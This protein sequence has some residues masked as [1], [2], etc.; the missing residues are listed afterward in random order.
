MDFV[1]TI[2]IYSIMTVLIT[3]K[4]FQKIARR[5]QEYNEGKRRA[6]DELESS[7]HRLRMFVEQCPYSVA[8]LDKDMRYLFCSDQ[9]FVSHKIEK[10]PVRG[11]SHYDLFPTSAKRRDIH[12]RCLAGA[13]E[14]N[15]GEKFMI[16][17]SWHWYRWEIRPWYN[18]E[19]DIG[20]VILYSEDITE[21]QRH[22]DRLRENEQKFLTIYENSPL[23]KSL[24]SWPDGRFCDVNS[25]WTE[26]FEFSKEEVLGK[27][28]I[29]LGI[30]Q[31]EKEREV[32]R[33]RL[34]DHRNS[35]NLEMKLYTKSGRQLVVTNNGSVFE[36]NGEK[37]LILT[38]M[39]ITENKK[40]ERQLAATFNQAGVGIAHVSPEG[41]WLRVNRKICE[42]VGYTETE[43]LNLSFQQITHPD[44]L[45]QDIS[46]LNQMLNH[47]IDQYTMEKRYI[48]KDQSTVW[49]N[50]TV[51][52]VWKQNG[53]PDYFISIIEDIDLRKQ[54]EKDRAD[55]AVREHSA[56]VASKLKS[57]FLSN[58]S[59]EIRTPINGVIGMTG[60]L[61][62]T[63]LSSE[64]QDYVNTIRRSGETL[65][66]V[67][68]DILDFSKIEA[69]KLD[70]EMIDFNLS[71]AIEDVRKTLIFSADK[72]NIKF[73][74]DIASNMPVAFKGDP[75]RLKQVLF[76][77]IGNAIK[78]TNKGS[79]S[80]CAYPIYETD[81]EAHI[82]FE[83][84]DTGIG[85]PIEIQDRLF[86]PFTQGDA[87]T[88][89]HFGGTGL[90]LTI[91]KSLIEKMNGHISI[92]SE[93]GSGSTF[94]FDI[95]LKKSSI[96]PLKKAE[97]E[98]PLAS[99]SRTR[100]ARIL[101][102]EDNLV[103]QLITTKMLQKLGYHADA[104]ANG[105]EVLKTLNEIPYDLILMDC[106]M[107]EM[108]GYEASRIIRQS[109]EFPYCNIPILALTANAMAG[110]AK[111]CRSAG[112]N[113]HIA[114][115]VTIEKLGQILEK[116]L[117]ETT[118]SS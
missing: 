97:T 55:L 23:P 98:V 73:S 96:K 78:F 43:L 57:E 52:L 93:E 67:I 111:V 101:V 31:D 22:Q 48:K 69:G 99:S 106:Q 36:L 84:K 26:L 16:N 27:T 72:K 64:Q 59:H 82:K 58:V 12:L 65:L 17:G 44:D 42:I 117:D 81:V 86:R 114:K 109:K 62:D 70:F 108:D 95:T 103:N 47:E 90:G 102:A 30:V 18:D 19:N 32:A 85:I 51:A 21:K 74:T 34:K 45:N 83:V 35:R 49:V 116:Y 118:R 53:Q 110:E 61:S 3:W 91:C 33:Q 79:V 46:L 25:A 9:W 92:Q 6:M 39:D 5:D 60:L 107:P 29:E 7:E 1:L 41:K 75:G 112:M 14:K 77:L 63:N 89:R 68:N 113:D 38:Q 4:G 88:H 56:Q 94:T 20:G 87:S 37:Y 8:M 54:A 104:V 24:L 13:V 76:N 115:P 2:A 28:T 80:L 66:T 11:L 100:K 105:K 15:E 40:L 10:R 71:D 50:L